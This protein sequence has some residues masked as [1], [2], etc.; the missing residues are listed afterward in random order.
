MSRSRCKRG[1]SST[2]TRTRHCM[3][4]LRF[5]FGQTRDGEG[6]VRATATATATAKVKVDM[7]NTNEIVA[8][9]RSCSYWFY[10]G[11]YTYISLCTA[12]ILFPC[13]AKFIKLTLHFGSCIWFYGHVA[14]DFR[15]IRL[16]LQGTF[17]GVG[18]L[19]Q[20]P[21]RREHC[22]I[23]I[24]QDRHS[25]HWCNWQCLA[26]NNNENIFI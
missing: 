15:G 20:L 9:P 18:K 10:V 5:D 14:S 2:R 7:A 19:I 25:N 6:H 13:A 22:N 8:P 24:L 11:V 17:L 16:Y 23:S 3:T 1:Q 21:H 4:A 26:C 12:H